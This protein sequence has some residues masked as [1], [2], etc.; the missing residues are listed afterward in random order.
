MWKMSDIEAA[1]VYECTE[2]KRIVVAVDPA[3]TSNEDSD[4][5][6]IIVC[7]IDH[8]GHGYVLE[9]CTM[10]TATPAQWATRAGEAA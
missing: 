5:K 4:V 9:D 7:G 8:D 1:R 2:L 3:V 6:G 10:T